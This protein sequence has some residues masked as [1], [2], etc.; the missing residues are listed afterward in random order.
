MNEVND[1]KSPLDMLQKA[2]IGASAA[3]FV[4]FAGFWIFQ[5]NSAYELLKLAYG[6]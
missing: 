6:W 4:A 2:A 3:V 5:I 1:R